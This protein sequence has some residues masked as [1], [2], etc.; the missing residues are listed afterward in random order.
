MN[1]FGRF[2]DVLTILIHEV[3]FELFGF[4]S[5]ESTQRTCS[6]NLKDVYCLYKSFNVFF[7]PMI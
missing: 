1:L 2:N 4:N 5:I 6:D 7:I 3:V